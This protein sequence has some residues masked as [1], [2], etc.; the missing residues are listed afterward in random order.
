MILGVTNKKVTKQLKAVLGDLASGLVQAKCFPHDWANWERV[1]PRIWPGS[2]STDDGI[3]ISFWRQGDT[4]N[5]VRVIRDRDVIYY[6]NPGMRR[7]CALLYWSKLIADSIKVRTSA[8]PETIM[9]E[10]LA[11]AS[12]AVLKDPSPDAEWLRAWMTVRGLEKMMAKS[13][14]Q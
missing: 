14:R 3:S 7:K 8:T 9:Q 13:E 11:I 10:S 4:V 6:V 5:A 12:A 1:S 2:L